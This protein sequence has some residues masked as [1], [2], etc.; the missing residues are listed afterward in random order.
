MSSHDLTLRRYWPY[1]LAAAAVYLIWRGFFMCA[2]PYNVDELAHA[3]FAWQYAQ[4]DRFLFEVCD[5]ARSPFLHLM[6]KPLF[7]VLGEGDLLPYR[8]AMALVSMAALV[9]FALTLVRCGAGLISTTIGVFAAAISAP[10][11]ISAQQIRYDPFVLFFLAAGFFTL[12]FAADRRW[13][14]VAT[15]AAGFCAMFAVGVKVL[16]AP[17]L[18]SFVLFALHLR[19]QTDEKPTSRLKILGLLFIGAT[20]P[21]AMLIAMFRPLLDVLLQLPSGPLDGFLQLHGTLIEGLSNIQIFRLMTQQPIFWACGLAS[22]YFLF[23]PSDEAPAFASFTRAMMIGAAISLFFVPLVK[24][25]F[26]LQ[27]L[28]LPALSVAAMM[29]LAG[30]RIW[31][32]GRS[33]V[34][35]GL[36]V[37]VA[38]SGIFTAHA[39]LGRPA[40]ERRAVDRRLVELQAA[41][42]EIPE[43][44]P[45]AAFVTLYKL[46]DPFLFEHF[47]TRREQSAAI[48]YFNEHVGRDEM[49]MAS[50]SLH[51]FRRGSAAWSLGLAV[52]GDLGL[53]FVFRI[54]RHIPHEVQC[55]FAS[56]ECQRLFDPR[57]SGIEEN[58]IRDLEFTRPR[59]ALVDRFLL[60][61][62]FEYPKYLD[63][64]GQN[65]VI[66]FDEASR[67]VFAHRTSR[68]W[69]GPELPALPPWDCD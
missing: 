61:L 28:L 36:V 57:A 21:V 29:A 62:W 41:L 67:R 65:Y 20:I 32:Q 60:D 39:N 54:S 4:G 55:F 26:Y 10:F 47:V 1:F 51:V 63:V 18:I 19:G 27:D 66:R 2:V 9:F 58:L 17:Y 14:V 11:L 6:L 8:A 42:A 45:R 69:Q 7:G 22:A 12:K 43:P 59:V 50:N 48:R 34:V 13:P 35:I 68:P 49:A 53:D 31:R 33:R 37:A 3:H 64:F 24:R 23:R 38:A 56:R 15:I 44:N 5:L 16:A 25:Q 52:V 30:A 46:Y 40:E